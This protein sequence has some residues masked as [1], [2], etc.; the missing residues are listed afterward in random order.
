[1]THSTF[2]IKWRGGG[3]NIPANLILT[4]YL[5]KLRLTAVKKCNKL[6]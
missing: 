6:V 4:T 1:M 3:A 2:A 5:L